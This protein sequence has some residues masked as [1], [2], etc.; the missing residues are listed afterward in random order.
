MQRDAKVFRSPCT[1]SI[2]ATGT[3]F[4]I[5]GSSSDRREQR[6][7]K[8]VCVAGG[9]TAHACMHD[10]PPGEIVREVVAHALFHWAGG[11]MPPMWNWSARPDVTAAG[12]DPDGLDQG[13]IL[14]RWIATRGERKIS[15]VALRSK[16]QRDEPEFHFIHVAR[17][18]GRAYEK[19]T[20]RAA[21]IFFFTVSF[22]FCRRKALLHAFLHSLM[23]LYYC[24][25]GGKAKK[26]KKKLAACMHACIV[27]Y[28]L[29]FTTSF[30][31]AGLYYNRAVC[32]SLK[33]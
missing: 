26:K 27:I 24:W 10:R 30:S 1:S 19:K 33:V 16:E 13:G 4:R 5:F 14:L 7:A 18:P 22:F 32:T 20:C 21:L 17:P 11:I 31:Y 8:S 15:P 12:D 9:I 6:N 25:I 23:C 3:A 28:C 29:Q 2:T